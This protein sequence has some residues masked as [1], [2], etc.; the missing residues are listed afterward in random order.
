MY[1]CLV[2]IFS[3]LLLEES[4]LLLLDT[5]QTLSLGHLAAV[6]SLAL[7][8]LFVRLLGFRVFTDCG[9]SFLV[10]TLNAVSCDS[11]FD[12]LRELSLV[13]FLVLISQHLHVICDMFAKDVV[14]VNLSIE[15]S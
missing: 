6:M 13:S 1:N 9:M 10:H 12:V 7:E 14:T 11:E 15:L 4:G 2:I 3:L 8:W 5:I